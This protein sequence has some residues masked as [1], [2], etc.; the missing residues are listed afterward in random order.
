M[1]GCPMISLNR[2]FLGVAIGAAALM[3][4]CNARDKKNEIRVAL[5][6]YDRLVQKMD[7]DSISMMYTP[8]GDLGTMAQGRDSIRKFLLTFVN[9]RVL[10][11][12]STSDNIEITGDSAMQLGKFNQ[13]ALVDN[14]DTVRPKGTYSAKWVWTKETGW[15]IRRMVTKPD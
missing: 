5:R 9:V 4:G 7:A 14:K 6:N 2:Y 8:D 10:S 1:P 11:V 13:V 3:V 12:S 15:K